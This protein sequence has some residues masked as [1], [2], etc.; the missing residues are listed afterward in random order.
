MDHRVAGRIGQVQFQDVPV[1]LVDELSEDLFGLFVETVSWFPDETAQQAEHANDEH[2]DNEHDR[3][4]QEVTASAVR[5]NKARE[6]RYDG[7]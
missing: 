5:L 2:T 3:H 6:P 1:I 7:S 4:A